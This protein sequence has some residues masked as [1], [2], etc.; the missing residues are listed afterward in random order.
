MKRFLVVV[1]IAMA[2][3]C[4]LQAAHVGET[5]ARQVANRFFS[6]HS[7]VFRA[8]ATQSALRLAY[9]AEN[10]RFYVFDHGTNSGFVVVAGDDRLP[11]VLGY[12]D[13]GDFSSASLP[14]AVQYWMG[15]MN[16]QIAY[17][18]THG[19]VMAHQPA[20]Q[21]VVVSPLLT[22]RWD[23]DAPYND[24]CPTYTTPGGAVLRAV[25]G[26]VAT[27][28]AQVMNYYQ[29]PDVGQGSHGYYCN[30]NDMTPTELSADFSQSVYQWDLMLNEYDENS[31]PE[32][33][34]A[35]AKLMSDVGISIDMNYGSSSGASEVVALMAL[36][37]YFKYND[38][39]YILSRDYYNAAEWDQFLVDEISAQRPIVYCGYTINP[40]SSG[41]H[42]FVLDGI[43]ADGY[44]HVN[45]GW[46]GSYDGY[47]LVSVLAPSSGSDFKY[48]Q[49]GFFGLVPEARAD[50]IDDVMY[51]RSQLIPVNP[52]VPLG[53]Q[54]ELRTDNFIVEGN[55][56]DTAGYEQFGDRIRYYA[57]IPA[58]FSVIDAAGVECVNHREDIKQ[59]LDNWFSFRNTY[60]FELP[61]TLADGE[62]KIKMNYSKDGGVN[63]DQKVRDFSGKDLYVKMT[64][65]NDTAYLTDCFLANSYELE[66]FVVPRGITTNESFTV[67]VNLSYEM[68]WSNIDGPKGNIY[69]SLLKD[70]NEVATSEMCEVQLHSNETKSYEMQL[71]APAEWGTYELMV[72]DE[73]GNHLQKME[74][75]YDAVDAVERILVLPPCQELVEDF[76][77]MTANSSTSQSNVQGN[78]TTWTFYKCGVRAPGEGKCNGTNAVMMKKPSHVTSA[79]PIA[80][81]FFMAQAT[82]FNP[83]SSEAKYRLTYSLD[84]GETWETANAFDGEDAITVPVKGEIVATWLLNITAN[85]PAIFRITMFGGGNAATY[86]DDFS[87]YYTDS[88]GNPCD[89]N[90]DGEV[91][92]G[93]VNSVINAILSPGE[94]SL[95][96]DVNG[97]GEVNIGDINTI[98]QAIMQ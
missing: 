42:C 53:S 84:N 69:L 94:Q 5:E 34:Y 36:K 74:G 31:S 47:F 71:T 72:N 56:L 85:Q 32:S 52:A 86:L 18:Q 8:P 46:G 25:T 37:R 10:E 89:V 92:L 60:E 17:L 54:V 90:G 19:N 26:C 13:E 2:T 76:E 68:R 61:S 15:E 93:D 27:G 30:V 40:T 50:E 65:R 49:D 55:M 3:V 66:S 33:C 63:F 16:R 64:V 59:S 88:E 1:A 24:L 62:Y 82:F 14:P 77:S 23:Q 20:K 29:W 58:S 51:I 87:L 6:A 38:N 48:M 97:D 11:Q 9:T 44:Y 73:S 95:P 57:L 78:F 21:S 35:V 75:W 91:N 96:A 81:D 67:G 80:H 83:T 43:D 7:T 12:G 70:G 39:S 4:G 79:E 22:T 28:V 98:I 45:W 41:G